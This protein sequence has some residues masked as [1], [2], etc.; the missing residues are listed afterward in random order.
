MPSRRSFPAFYQALPA[1]APAP[2]PA[3]TPTPATTSSTLQTTR[4]PRRFSH[5]A[6]GVLECAWVTLS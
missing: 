4:F 6:L 2:A 5:R 1:P 3:A